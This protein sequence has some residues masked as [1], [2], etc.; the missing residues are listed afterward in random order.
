MRIGE[1]GDPCGIPFLTGFISPWLLSRHIAA[2]RLER[3]FAIYFTSS[4][5]MQCFFI[6]LRRCSWLTKSKYPLISK[7]S[8][9]V[10]RLWFHEL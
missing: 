3:K 9:E 5:G 8:A 1:I 10:A 6:L 7:V 4:R 2:S